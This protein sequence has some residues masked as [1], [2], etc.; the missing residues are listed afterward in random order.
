MELSVYARRVKIDLFFMYRDTNS[1][2][3]G[4]MIVGQRKKLRWDYPHVDELCTGDLLG[5][6]FNVP[7]NVE[8][9]L[10]VFFF[11]NL[12]VLFFKPKISSFR[13][14]DPEAWPW[15]QSCKQSTVRLF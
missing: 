5:I 7:C 8:K 12:D 3:V 10:E 9:V 4:G 13:T 15:L 14:V 11:I 2:W 1:D 6:L